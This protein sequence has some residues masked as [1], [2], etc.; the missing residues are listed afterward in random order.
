MAANRKSNT[1]MNLITISITIIFMVTMVHCGALNEIG[2]TD[3][4][5]NERASERSRNLAIL[6]G[7]YTFS[8]VIF[9]IIGVLLSLSLIGINVFP[10][11][12]LRTRLSN[13]ESF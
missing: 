4:E 13:Y 9:A 1:F 6:F 5:A 11:S 2:D 7:F 12:R 10:S 3:P 8:M